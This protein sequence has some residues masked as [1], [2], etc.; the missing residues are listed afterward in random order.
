MAKG[1]LIGLSEKGL[2]LDL[3]MRAVFSEHLMR[4]PRAPRYSANPGG[5]EL[6]QR[7]FRKLW[8]DAGTPLTAL[9]SSII[10]IVAR[11]PLSTKKVFVRLQKDGKTS[12]EEFQAMIDDMVR[13]DLLTTD[14][15]RMWVEG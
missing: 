4:D 15:D 7:T 9:K 6:I 12:P 10:S 1:P 3:M 11:R 8:D 13:A 14:P 5:L 2:N